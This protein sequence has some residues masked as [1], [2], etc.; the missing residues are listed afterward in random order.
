MK[1]QH[2]LLAGQFHALAA[3]LEL[4][5]NRRKKQVVQ[6]IVEYDG[7]KL[8]C[9]NQSP[10]KSNPIQRKKF[11]FKVDGFS[12]SEWHLHTSVHSYWG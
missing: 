3:P 10:E 8:Q 9:Y 4:L 2:H 12:L 6:N 1:P 5:L 7:I 11:F